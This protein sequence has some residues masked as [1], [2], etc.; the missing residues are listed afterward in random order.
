MAIIV[1]VGSISRIAHG[2]TASKLGMGSSNTRVNLQSVELSRSFRY[3]CMTLTYD[4]N[5]NT[6]PKSGGR[7]GVGVGRCRDGSRVANGRSLRDTL[8]TPWSAGT[9]GFDGYL[10]LRVDY[11]HF[12]D[13]AEGLDLISRKAA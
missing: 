2:S 4:I 8:K 10:D 3:I 6:R 11:G 13:A 1:R 12:G 7:V 5:I 9:G